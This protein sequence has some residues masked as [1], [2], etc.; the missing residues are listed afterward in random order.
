[1]VLFYIFRIFALIKNQGSFIFICLSY[2]MQNILDKNY[3]SEQDVVLLQEALSGSRRALELLLKRHYAYIY[4][5]ALRFVLKPEDAEDLTQEVCIKVITKLAQFN[6]KSDF[7]TWLYRIVF[8]HFLNNKRR[9]TEQFITSF[10]QY[11]EG[12]EHSI[13]EDLTEQESLDWKEKIEDYKIECMTG[14]LLCLNRMQ[15]LVF[16]LAEMF[17][18]DSK[19]GAEVLA[20][21]PENYRKV[22]SRARKD[23]YHFMNH[24]CGLKTLVAVPVKPR[25]R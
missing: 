3:S 9:N 8:N 21:S 15:C 11:G 17:E 20:M 4:N 2:T 16:I 10:G 1:M 22:L 5:I 24:K 6:Q 18:V 25:S 23:L 7:R 12:L 13:L 19:T 14:M